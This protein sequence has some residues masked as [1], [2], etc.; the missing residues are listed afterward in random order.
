[1]NQLQELIKAEKK[2]AQLF[3]EIELRGIV[4]AGKT[5]KELNKE[6][7]ELAFELFGIRKYW[8]KRIV[9]SGKNT[10]LP[11]RANPENLILQKDDI[12]FFDFGPVF[13]EWEADFGRTYVIGNNDLKLKLQ[14]D[15]ETAWHEGKDY[16]LANRESITGAEFYAYTRKL[17]Q[18]YGWEYGNEH[19]GHLIGNFPHERIVGEETIH[20][21]H[22]ENDQLMNA[23]DQHGNPR[24]W[25]YEIHFVNTELEIGGFF[26][27]LLFES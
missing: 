9:R 12:L 25:I 21:I 13:D 4:A 8:H 2:A 7:M 19:C 27:Q 10:L 22:P 1:M 17:A 18:K 15:V 24:E 5:E 11:Y 14:Q 3:E 20:Y 26:E 6:V 23:P 16:F